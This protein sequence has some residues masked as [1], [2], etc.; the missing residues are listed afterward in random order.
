M[1]TRY[2]AL[3]LIF[4]GVIVCAIAFT[5]ASLWATNVYLRNRNRELKKE[6]DY[7]EHRLMMRYDAIREQQLAEEEEIR[8]KE[9]FMQDL[10]NNDLPTKNNKKKK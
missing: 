1:E 6:R 5:I 10:I 3:I 8:R 9:K 4:A 2:Q 7:Y